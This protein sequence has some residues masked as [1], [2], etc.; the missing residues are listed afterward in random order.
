MYLSETNVPIQYNSVHHSS[1]DP[2]LQTTMGFTVPEFWSLS[3]QGV[4]SVAFGRCKVPLGRHGITFGRG[5]EVSRPS[6][7][8]GSHCQ[9]ACN[10]RA[11]NNQKTVA[12][13]R[14]NVDRRWPASGPSSYVHSRRSGITGYHFCINILGGPA[15]QLLFSRPSPLG[16]MSSNMVFGS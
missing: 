7:P 13:W 14:A 8:L 15:Y 1:V 5:T 4:N 6:W 11:S 2:W 10:D 3:V 9:P 12:H 16:I